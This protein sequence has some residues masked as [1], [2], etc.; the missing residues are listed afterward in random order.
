MAKD[1]EIIE[2]MNELHPELQLILDRELKVGNHVLDASRGWPDPGSL[3]ITLREPFH[4]GY[5]VTDSVEYSEPNDP[6]YWT[7]DYSCG[8]PLHIIAN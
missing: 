4:R 5:E 2:C 7:A 8:N 6:H 1:L 3:F